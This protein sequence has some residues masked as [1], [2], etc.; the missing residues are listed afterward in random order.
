MGR[1]CILRWITNSEFGLHFYENRSR[2]EL[3]NDN[4]T[5]RFIVDKKK[6]DGVATDMATTEQ[7]NRPMPSLLVTLLREYDRSA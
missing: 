4:S 6:D 7:V 2:S 1:L 3:R 5:R